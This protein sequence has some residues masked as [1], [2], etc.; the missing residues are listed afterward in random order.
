[1]GGGG[2]DLKNVFLIKAVVELYFL[3]LYDKSL[4]AEKQLSPR[5]RKSVV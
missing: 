2:G 1:M 5:D 3:V 4:Q